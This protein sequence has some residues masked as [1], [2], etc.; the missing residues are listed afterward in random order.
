M[1]NRG[2]NALLSVL[3]SVV[4]LAGCVR[5]DSFE[6]FVP[7]SR[8][9]DGV[10]VFDFE[11][12]DSTRLY[13]LY[14]FDRI[15]GNRPDSLPLNVM[16]ISPSGESFS[17]TVYMDP[18]KDTELYRS[19]IEPYEYGSWRLCVRPVGVDRT[20]RGMGIVCKENGTR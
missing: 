1:K 7:A 8:A 18:E 10:Y 14:F 4:A 9:A 2:L 13:D 15:D 11:M 5:P 19:G 16:W 3:V 12:P 17:E 20:F 6:M